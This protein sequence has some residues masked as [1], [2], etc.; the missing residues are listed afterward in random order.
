MIRREA[1]QDAPHVALPRFTGA[2]MPKQ[3]LLRIF[4]FTEADEHGNLAA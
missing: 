2:M 1:V 4:H 3:A